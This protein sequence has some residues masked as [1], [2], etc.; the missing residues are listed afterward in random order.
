M[1]FSALGRIAA[2]LVIASSAAPS[3]AAA[4]AESGASPLAEAAFA[5][6]RLVNL[7]TTRTL[8]RGEALFRVS[9]R[10]IY[11]TRS[12]RESLYGLDGPAA[13]YLS[14]G[15]GFT[16]ALQATLGR[17]NLRDEIDLEIAWRFLEQEQKRP[18]PVAASIVVAGSLT[19]ETAEG[20][21]VFRSDNAHASVQLVVSRMLGRGVS[22]MAV[23]SYAHNTDYDRPG[24]ETTVALGLGSRVSLGEEV[25]VAAEWTPVLSGFGTARDAWAFGVEAAPGG[26][27]FHVF[28]T[29]ASGLTTNQF[30]PGG[31][32]RGEAGE[33]RFGFNI[34]RTLWF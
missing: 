10:F 13:I 29:N 16:D 28:V 33:L 22:V 2:A 23:P 24:E 25:S 21:K 20:E 3:S 34:Y 8:S 17:T 18:S 11:P 7:P 6:G 1:R 27:V 14:L 12:G 19:T 31:D 30:L 26:H 32:L 4:A 5:C 15:Y 9:H